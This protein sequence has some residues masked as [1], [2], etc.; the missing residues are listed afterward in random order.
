M[1]TFMLVFLGLFFYSSAGLSWG[2][3]WVCAGETFVG[4]KRTAIGD[5]GGKLSKYK[6][7]GDEVRYYSNLMSI[8]INHNDEFYLIASKHSKDKNSLAQFSYLLID[9]VKKQFIYDFVE[10]GDDNSRDQG[11]CIR[12]D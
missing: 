11:E 2:E 7:V 1:R 6:I 10:V 12:S 8:P 4:D 9:K 3:T 5:A